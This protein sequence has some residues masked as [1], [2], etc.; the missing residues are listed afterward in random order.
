MKT[1]I[2]YSTRHGAAKKCVEVLQPQLEGELTVVNAKE[3]TIPDIQGFDRVII[4]SSIYAGMIGKTIKKFVTANLDQLLKK[5]SFLFV[6]GAF[7]NAEYFPKNFPDSLCQHAQEKVNFGGEL[8]TKDMGFLEKTI[9]KMVSAKEK[10]IPMIHEDRI[11][12]FSEAVN[13]VL[14]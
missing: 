12:A 7:D 8:N 4:G 2:I 9:V 13:A 6:C 1:L 14:S 5:A 10:T 3:D 11:K